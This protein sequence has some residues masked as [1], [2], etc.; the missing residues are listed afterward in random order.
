MRGSHEVGVR[1][2][3]MAGEVV[4]VNQLQRSLHGHPGASRARGSGDRRLNHEGNHTSC[5]HRRQDRIPPNAAEMKRH[6]RFVDRNPGM[7]ENR[8]G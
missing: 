8:Y 3:V 7:V 1:V 5:K 4:G 2:G 6:A